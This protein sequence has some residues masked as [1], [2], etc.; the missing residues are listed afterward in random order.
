MKAAYT[1]QKANLIKVP[2]VSAISVS[3][4]AKVYLTEKPGSRALKAKENRSCRTITKFPILL[5]LVHESIV[6]VDMVEVQ[7]S[8]EWSVQERA[9]LIATP[10]FHVYRCM[11]SDLSLGRFTEAR[12]PTLSTPS[13]IPRSPSVH[14][15]DDDLHCC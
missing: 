3:S 11:R 6:R 8:T 2:P 4:P 1:F 7:R 5:S 9:K 14:H 12:P 13:I 15:Y 10:G